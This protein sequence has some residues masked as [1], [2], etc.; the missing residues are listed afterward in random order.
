VFIVAFPGYK[1]GLQSHVHQH[2]SGQK[3][4]PPNIILMTVVAQ[5]G[6][7]ADPVLPPVVAVALPAPCPAAVAVEL[8]PVV[9]A[10]PVPAPCPVA[11]APPVL[12][13]EGVEDVVAGAVMLVDE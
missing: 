13:P 7:V 6:V 10:V 8:F 1:I 9:V 4:I 11:L 3:Y 2:W 5:V 12:L